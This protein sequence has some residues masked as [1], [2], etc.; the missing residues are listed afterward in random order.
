MLAVIEAAFADVPM[1]GGGYLDHS[2]T[3]KIPSW[4][5]CSHIEYSRAC[6]D[7]EDSLICSPGTSSPATLSALRQLELPECL[8]GGKYEQ[9]PSCKG[10]W[11]SV[12]AMSA[13]TKQFPAG[14]A[15]ANYFAVSWTNATLSA[16]L[17]EAGGFGPFKSYL[18]GSFDE[19]SRRWAGLGGKWGDTGGNSADGWLLCDIMHSVLKL[20]NNQVGGGVCGPTGVLAALS[21][22]DPTRSMR[23]LMELLWTGTL[24]ELGESPPCPAVFSQFPGLVPIPDASQIDCSDSVKFPNAGDCSNSLNMPLQAVGVQQAFTQAMLSASMRDNNRAQG[25]AEPCSGS[26]Q[27]LILKTMDNQAQ[28]PAIMSSQGTLPSQL[29]WIASKWLG[30]EVRFHHGKPA[31]CEGLF[32]GDAAEQRRK[33]DLFFSNPGLTAPENPSDP[34]KVLVLRADGS[35]DTDATKDKL[36]EFHP[37]WA[38]F[39]QLSQDL[40]PRPLDVLVN[41]SL[42]DIPPLGWPDLHDD[43]LAEACAAKAAIVTIASGNLGHFKDKAVQAADDGTRDMASFLG[44]LSMS[45][46]PNKC[47]H[48]VFLEACPRSGVPETGPDAGKYNIWSWGE[49]GYMISKKLLKEMVCGFTF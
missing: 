46:A 33:C 35:V 23:K 30:R 2:A 47:D 18:A 38:G 15:F 4:G 6:L 31:L 17:A 42:Y 14:P 28:W 37:H 49:S 19:S 13:L 40:S 9:D 27:D 12:R 7:A 36:I 21:R 5:S 48:I 43:V 44:S 10:F 26:G 29:A 1:T 45:A 24:R 41:A 20:N 11:A 16:S 8:P 22:T 32:E 3:Q 39:F 25:A 34:S